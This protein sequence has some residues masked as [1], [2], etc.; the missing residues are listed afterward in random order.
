MTDTSNIMIDYAR[1]PDEVWQRLSD[2]S[3]DAA[4]WFR[5]HVVATV[6][7]DNRPNARTLVLRGVKRE[8]ALL[9]FHTDARTPKVEQLRANTRICTVCYDARLGLQLRFD[10]IATIHHQDDLACHHWTQHGLAVK[11]AYGISHR[12]GERIAE[13]DPR[14]LKARERLAEGREADGYE[15]FAVIEMRIEQID[16]FQTTAMMQRRALLRA[17]HDWQPEPLSP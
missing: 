14:S 10:G 2:A 6:D 17:S 11:Y 8:D 7:A 1:M 15:H 12:P 4:H 13:N 3:D 16:W 5:L 9:W